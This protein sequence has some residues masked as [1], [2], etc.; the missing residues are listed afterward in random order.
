[1]LISRGKDGSLLWVPE[2]IQPIGAFR[3]LI[4][5]CHWHRLVMVCNLLRKWFYL[6]ITWIDNYCEV[7]LA[8]YSYLSVL[9]SSSFSAYHAE[10]VQAL[11]EIRFRFRE[12]TQPHSYVS[13]LASE[14]AEDYPPGLF[15]KA[16]YL[17]T[18]WDEPLFQKLLENFNPQKGQVMLMAREHPNVIPEG[19]WKIEKWYGTEY[20]VQKLEPWLV[21]KVGG[22]VFFFWNSGW[23]LPRQMIRLW[24]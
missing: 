20:Y 1:M 8:I 5:E 18:E 7:L 12:K 2:R 10:E 14:L 21:Q 6:L 23:H 22:L 4:F 13:W 19:G 16:P 15:L 11:A 3:N 9:R 24:N 17:V